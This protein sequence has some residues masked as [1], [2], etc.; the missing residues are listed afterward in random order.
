[1]RH[2]R[3]CHRPRLLPQQLS[4]HRELLWVFLRIANSDLFDKMEHRRRQED[5]GCYCHALVH[6]IRSGQSI[7][8][9]SYAWSSGACN[10]FIVEDEGKLASLHFLVHNGPSI[11]SH[12][13][14]S[15]IILPNKRKHSC[16]DHNQHPRLSLLC[17]HCHGPE[18]NAFHEPHLYDIR[19]SAIAKQWILCAVAA[20]PLLNLPH[21][22]WDEIFVEVTCLV[23]QSNMM[24]FT[25]STQKQK[26]E[27][28]VDFV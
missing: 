28:V 23:R 7:N 27:L 10:W 18:P 6:I 17:F 19:N 20:Y 14:C 21:K 12:R 9:L 2:V 26:A 3:C 13:I 4:R 1:M 16:C 11:G 8:L 5:N 25:G 22:T 15:D 24:V